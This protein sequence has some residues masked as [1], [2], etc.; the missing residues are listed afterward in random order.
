M[1]CLD[2]IKEKIKEKELV[3]GTVLISNNNCVAE[4]MGKVGFDFVWI[5][6]EH[7]PLDKK[8]I[9][10]HIMAA[11][12]AGSAAFVRVAWN[13]PVLVKPILEMGVD[14]I[15]FPYIRNVKDAEKAVSSCLYP[16][17]GIRGSGPIRAIA[18]GVDDESEYI[19]KS[20]SLVWKILQIEHIDAVNNLDE[21]LNVEGVDAIMVGPMDL[22]GSIGLLGQIDHPEV[23]KLFDKIAK[24]AKEHNIPFGA[25]AGYNLKT[26]NE[27][28]TRG[29]NWIAVC[30][31][32]SLVIKSAKDI[33]KDIGEILKNKK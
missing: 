18:Y 3:I 30:D 6:G 21:I 14:G 22:S 28:V 10:Y 27:W 29:I 19:K 8:E 2:K 7:A 25:A 31:D 32:Y 16:P 12:G 20:S 13:D 17:R 5:D 33:L 15:I 23:K 26:I 11:Q 24:K 1:L 9:L 4:L